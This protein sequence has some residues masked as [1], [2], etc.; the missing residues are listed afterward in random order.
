MTRQ[1]ESLIKGMTFKREAADYSHRL[2]VIT[3]GNA[4]KTIHVAAC[5]SVA[6]A[7]SFVAC[8]VVIESVK[9]IQLVKVPC[10]SMKLSAVCEMK[11][12]S[13]AESFA[14]Q[15]KVGCFPRIIET[16]EDSF[17]SDALPANECIGDCLS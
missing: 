16:I 9:I 5:L 3:R 17:D 11:R 7:F 12:K 4:A 13:S 10:K 8:A 15:F 1:M 6:K 14:V 2:T